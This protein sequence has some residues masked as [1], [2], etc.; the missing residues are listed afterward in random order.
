[1]T[2]EELL[3]FKILKKYNLKKNKIE[4]IKKIFLNQKLLNLNDFI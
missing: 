1:M 4:K 2:Q 3:K